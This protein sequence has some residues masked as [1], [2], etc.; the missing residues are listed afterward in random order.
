MRIEEVP[1]KT[2]RG[3]V[4]SKRLYYDGT[5]NK[6]MLPWSTFRKGLG[7]GKLLWNP[8]HFE[9]ATFMFQI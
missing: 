4:G 7:L 3:L 8:T 1:A 5:I 2:Y 6:M 9:I